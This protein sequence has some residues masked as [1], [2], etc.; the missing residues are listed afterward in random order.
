MLTDAALRASLDAKRSAAL[1][2][3]GNRHI[4]ATPVTRDS[5]R[6]LLQLQATVPIAAVTPLIEALIS[7][8]IDLVG[9]GVPHVT[10]QINR[11]EKAIRYALAKAEQ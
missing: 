6:A 4:L 3:L 8:D 11:A 7:D 9:A 10:A 5:Q 1:Q 2:Y